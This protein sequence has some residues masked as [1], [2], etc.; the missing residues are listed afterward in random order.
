M[1]QQSEFQLKYPLSKK[2]FWK[3]MLERGVF[4]FILSFL[5][6]VITAVM[7]L[8]NAHQDFTTSNII[9][10]SIISTFVMLVFFYIILFLTYGVYVHFYIKHY[11]YD[12]ADKL[13]TIRKGV[14]AVNEIHVQYQKIQDVFVDQD[15][16][17]RMLGLYDVHI[18][19]TTFNSGMEA[20]IDGVDSVGADYI[21]SLILKKIGGSIPK[22]I[23]IPMIHSKQSK[24]K[25]S[26]A[27]YPISNKWLFLAGL[28]SLFYVLILMLFVVGFIAR[29]FHTGADVTSQSIALT[30]YV[31]LGFAALFILTII[32]NWLWKKA[33]Y[34]EFFPDYI[35]L[36][37]GIISKKES[38][39]P[40]KAIQDVTVSRGVFERM[41]GLS[42]V[43]ITNAAQFS[44]S[45]QNSSAIVIPG[46]PREKAEELSKVLN[47]I[48]GKLGHSDSDM[49]V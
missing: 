39:L 15:V 41:L 5:A 4:V 24:Q 44:Q 12:C 3:K 48:L 35:Q 46:Q 10:T 19:S 13:V 21:K 26:S 17:D 38:H 42:T 30:R 28:S 49:G 34:F 6:G 40:Y 29:N 11:Y 32:T 31:M 22:T 8:T 20:H 2:K 9:T 37:T 47:E 18:A 14:F 16:F 25:I 27:N 1:D 7:V 43:I 45:S 36:K 23:K 33:Y